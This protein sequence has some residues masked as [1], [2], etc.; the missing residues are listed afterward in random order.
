MGIA[1]RPLAFGIAVVA[2]ARTIAAR[3]DAEVRENLDC[4]MHGS[5][6]IDMWLSVGQRVDL[7]AF[8]EGREL[9]SDWDVDM[10]KLVAHLAEGYIDRLADLLGELY[11]ACHSPQEAKSSGMVFT[12][13]WL[14]NRV[15][16][17]ALAHWRRLHR[18]GQMP[19]FI[20]D[21]SCGVGAFLPAIRENFGTIPKVVGVDSDP[22]CVAFTLLLGQ[23]IKQHWDVSCFDPLLQ[24]AFRYTLFTESMS[25]PADGFNLL[26]GNPPYV[27]AQA[28]DNNY[29]RRLKLAYPKVTVGNF[30]LVV[31]FLEHALRTLAP[32]GIA[33]YIVSHKF[34]VSSYGRSICQRLASDA[35]IINIVDFQDS[36]IFEG[37]T[38]YTSVLTFAKMPPSKYFSVTRFSTGVRRQDLGKGVTTSLRSER[39]H[40]HPWN[41][42]AGL[43][44]DI[45]M[46]LHRPS[47]PLI[48]QVFADIRQGIRTGANS[49][50]I[51]D[52]LR[53]TQVEPEVLLPLVS[54]EDIRRCR[55]RS[56]RNLLLYPYASDEYG[57]VRPYSEEELH[58]RFPKTWDYFSSYRVQLSERK[59]EPNQPWY[60]YSRS[61]NLGI[62]SKAKILVRE[63]MP[64]AEF[65][66]DCEGQLAFCS[67][68]ALIAPRM[69]DGELRLWAAVLS[70]PTMEFALRH[71]GTQLHSG[72]FRL[73]KHHLQTVR[74]PPMSPRAYKH[75]L[76]IA[77]RL[78]IDPDIEPA[79]SEFDDIV[80]RSFGLTYAER[81][82]IQTFLADCHAR[83]MSDSTEG[84]SLP[85]LLN[86]VGTLV[87]TARYEPVRLTQY[88]V[89][90]RDRADLG[91]SVTFKPNKQLPIHRWYCFH[92]GFSEP[93]VVNLLEELKISPGMIVLD[94]FCG[95]GTT[96]LTCRRNNI[97]SVGVEI[98]PLMVWVSRVKTSVWNSEELRLLIRVVEAAQPAPQDCHALLFEEF[99]GKAYAPQILAQLVGL[100][101][102]VD[103]ADIAPQ[104]RE[105]LRLG[106]ASIM[107]EVSQ[108]RKHGSHYRFMLKSESAGLQKLNT[109]IVEA[110]YDVI[111][112]YIERLREMADDVDT[113]DIP[114]PSV[115]CQVICADAKSTGLPDSYVDAVITSPPYLNRNN[116]IA[117]QKADIS[118]LGM[119]KSYKDY[120]DL[121]RRT[122]RSHVESDLGQE[123]V[124]KFPEV[125]KIVEALT[126]SD[127]NNPK[128]PHMIAGYFEDLD[129]TLGELWRL[130]RPGSE[131]AFVVGNSR[132]GGIVVPVDHLLLMLAERHRF[133]PIRV[134][135]TREKG[136][137]PQQM[138]RYGRIP[139]R[140]SVVIFRK[141]KPSSY[142]SSQS[143]V[144]L[145]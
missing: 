33:S 67:G 2:A 129:A 7:S 83:S 103:R 29:R 24:V 1:R 136:N 95:C 101:S 20:A 73:L 94:P 31:L 5:P 13:S 23:A 56:D 126:L 52:R 135:V 114:S 78:H 66:A 19:K 88:D 59:L 110:S 111:T 116:Y 115:D 144:D 64:R 53:A 75:A 32:G 48:T 10:R 122:F 35:R 106:V 124:T 84:K 82:A 47:N 55:I 86:P 4:W 109:Q 79:W 65:A 44:R 50:Y 28:L 16:R 112:K 132:W 30:D 25:V 63:M 117:Q 45:L 3:G 22:L 60:A 125:R 107:E 46:K 87:E 69:T 133:E 92:Q 130:M 42:V 9:L 97:A 57:N 138:R 76:T 142:T 121:V 85:P 72:W 137:S 34:M 100:I 70:T 36:Q 131:A 14:A 6:G 43:D 15:S 12:P 89:L 37:Y 104:H 40:E 139:T 108:I 49:I 93:L 120:R 123:P 58:E 113:A 118:L 41:F 80:A 81:S 143:R 105:F 68:Y 8:E 96:L 141:P 128:I 18:Y 26:I 71:S 90:H 119:V 62:S 140:E 17:D 145:R 74:L 134:L 61:Q 27:R 102:W 127:N 38:T 11:L 91:Q 54:G 99:L 98:S 21:V 51:L 77:N 39:L